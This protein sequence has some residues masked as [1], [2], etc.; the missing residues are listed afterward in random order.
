MALNLESL[1]KLDKEVLPGMVLDYKDK[2]DTFLTNINKEL[3]DLQ[4]KFTKLESDLAISININTKLSSQMTKVERKRWGN[5]QYSR[6]K[7]LENSGIP[8]SISQNDLESKVCD[9]SRE[10]DADI[11]PVN[12]KACHHLKS[13]H[14][15][16]KSHCKISGYKSCFENTKGKEEA[17]N[18]RPESEGFSTHHHCS[19]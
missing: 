9:I 11:D 8:D 3:T 2:F 12:I 7:C 15:F 16:K 17:K 18:Y 5:E 1:M 13:N 14:W 10:F 4:N 19:Y 6:R